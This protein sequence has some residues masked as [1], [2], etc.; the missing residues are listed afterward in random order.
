MR[1]LLPA[2]FTAAWM[3]RN[4]QRSAS[5][6]FRRVSRRAAFFESR[7]VRAVGRTFQPFLRALLIDF[8]ALRSEF[9]LQTTYVSPRARLLSA[10][11]SPRAFGTLPPAAGFTLR[12]GAG[13]GQY[14][15]R[16]TCPT[17]TPVAIASRVVV[18]ARTMRRWR[19]DMGAEPTFYS[20]SAVPIALCAA[21]TRAIGTRY[22][23]QL[24]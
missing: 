11:A 10:D 14:E 4:R 9:D 22:G 7:C 6:R 16:S 13:L 18:V 1:S 2:R 19:A 5:R 21:A 8:V 20:G 15:L 23:E 12:S 3:W 17:A 24:T